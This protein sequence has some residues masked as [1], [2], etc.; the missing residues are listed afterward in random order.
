MTLMEKWSWGWEE[1]R[2]MSGSGLAT[3]PS[4][5]PVL[6]LSP[7]FEHGAQVPVRRYA[8]GRTLH[9]SRW[10]HSRLFLFYSSF[11]D[12]YI[13]LHCIVTLGWNIVGSAGT[14]NET[15]GGARGEDGGRAAEG[16]GSGRGWRQSGWGWRQS[17][18][19]CLNIRG[20]FM[21]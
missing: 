16:G 21:L 12:F 7:R 9:G 19:I 20:V 3:A 18:C 10:T 15:P 13:L 2:S 4:T 1:A 14:R 5:R 6:P 8:H 11:I 17:G